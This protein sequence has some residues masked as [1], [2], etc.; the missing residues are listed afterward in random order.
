MVGFYEIDWAVSQYAG[1]VGYKIKPRLLT[2]LT[3]GYAYRSRNPRSVYPHCSPRATYNADG[4]V[5]GLGGEYEMGPVT[6]FGEYLHTGYKTG[7]IPVLHGE[8][9]VIDLDSDTIRF[10]VKFKFPGNM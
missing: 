10:G 1:R 5:L 7:T 8:R 9:H 3:G 4:W 2:Y 6:L